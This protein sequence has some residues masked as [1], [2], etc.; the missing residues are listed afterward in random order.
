MNE[1]VNAID[2]LACDQALTFGM[3]CGVILSNLWSSAI[4]SSTFGCV[5]VRGR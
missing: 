4:T 3:Y 2:P 5:V 1:L